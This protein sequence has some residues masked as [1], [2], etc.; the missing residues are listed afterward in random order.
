MPA[1]L[2]IDL[3]TKIAYDALIN[4][5]DASVAA[6]KRDALFVFDAA[7]F[8]VEIHG[9][10]R[11]LGIDS[12]RRAFR[13]LL[14]KDLRDPEKSIEQFG[15]VAYKTLTKGRRDQA[16]AALANAAAPLPGGAAPIG[17]P[18][19]VTGQMDAA[20]AGL[21]KGMRTSLLVEIEQATRDFA[22]ASPTHPAFVTRSARLGRAVGDLEKISGLLEVN[23]NEAAALEFFLLRSLRHWTAKN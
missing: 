22:L 10:F 9:E 2:I 14:S 5:P 19:G 21:H 6:A 20:Q 8:K 1:N 4:N 23:L 18:A 12:T 16:R 13:D 15:T 11:D 17:P 3:K 7:N